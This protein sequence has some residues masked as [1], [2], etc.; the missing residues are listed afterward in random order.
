[1][2]KNPVMLSS[3]EGIRQGDPLG[4]VLFSLV[5]YNISINL[6]S[7]LNDTI[8]LA[9]LDDVLLV[10]SSLSVVDASGELKEQFGK[11]RLKFQDQKCEMRTPLL[12]AVVST[13]VIGGYS[14]HFYWKSNS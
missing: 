11:F 8:V 2:N 13:S 3:Q 9:Y 4:P 7:T 12:S 6:L 14:C 5:I 1:M 10:G